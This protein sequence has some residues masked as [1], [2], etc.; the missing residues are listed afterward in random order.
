MT[1]VN[2]KQDDLDTKILRSSAWAVLG[3]GGTQALS[4]LTMLV[5][6][7]LLAPED[8][9]VVALAIA[10]IAVAQVAQESGMGAALIVHRGDLR[11]AA[12]SV[13][14]FSP[15]M[16]CGLYLSCFA[17]APV[18]AE[19][20]DEPELT[21]V[22]RAMA[23]ALVLR[24]LAIMPLSL[25]QRE[26]RFRSITVI[27]LGGGLAQAATAIAL[28]L[29]G[30]GVWSLVAG[31]L[32][33]GVVQLVLAWCFTPLRPSPF[34][35]RRETLGR[36]MRFGRHV[37]IANLI[38]YGNAN[39]EGLVVGRVLGATALGYYTIASRHATM[40][41]KVIGNILGRGVFPALSRVH[42]DP[43]R[44]RRIWL[45]N[46]QRLA[47]L[48]TPAAI[49]LALVAEPFVITFLGEKWRPAVV[50]LQILALN[51]IVRTFSA[52][53]GE[54]FQALQKPKLRV[55][56][57]CAYLVLIVPAVAVGAHWH[58]LEGAAAAVVLVNVAF[59]VSLLAGIMNLLHVAARELAEALLRPAAGWALLAASLLMLRP[60]VDEFSSAFALFALVSV[61]A[62]VYTVVVALFARKI[63]VTMWLSLRGARTSG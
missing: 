57:E 44:F 12:A 38:N 40:P 55:Y 14:V 59:G 6:A 35:A 61:G 54:V 46:V 60:M 9:G 25:L 10:I 51:G 43:V 49:G 29:S 26:M 52:T 11:R 36:L 15:L 32:A 41:V 28:G 21:S 7:R 18:F 63:V 23:L 2:P 33:L 37:G 42:D 34:E 3:Y 19:I 47:L 20:F 50:P 27:E 39:A 62:V 30:A 16:A 8:F 4:F 13:S 5:L 45:D 56:S 24:G 31:Q 58:G 22:L 48:S 53:A 17:A 1:E